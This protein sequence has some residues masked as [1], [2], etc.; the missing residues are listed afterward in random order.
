MKRIAFKM[1]LN[2]GMKEEYKLRHANIW[3]EI[4][5]LLK[6]SGVSNYSIFYD[7]ETCTLF[8]CQNVAETSSQELGVK[9]IMHKWWEY[10]SDIMETND[11]KSPVSIELE[12]VFHLE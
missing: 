11:D 6:K 3:P 1:K 2:K 5:S 7:S 12:E 10:M 4:T 9:P 8:A